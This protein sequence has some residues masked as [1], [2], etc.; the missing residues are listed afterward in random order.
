MHSS[1]SYRKSRIQIAAA[2]YGQGLDST[3]FESLMNEYHETIIERS[4]I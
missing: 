2:A 3:T 4:G 1:S